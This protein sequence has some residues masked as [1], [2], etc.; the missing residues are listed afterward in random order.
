[1]NIEKIKE[2]TEK[3]LKRYDLKL[4]SIR[5]KH[6]FGMSIL[7][8][9]VDGKE[10]DAANLGK[11]NQALNE[12]IDEYLPNNYY[13]EVSTVGAIRVLHSIE[14]VKTKV[15]KYLLITKDNKSI[16]G[17]LEKVED[18]ILFIKINE[19]GR[20]KVVE[21]SFTQADEVLLTVKF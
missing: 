11:I 4:Y 13:L 8:V 15:G 5:T 20:I 19:K 7:E 3:L 6:E 9:L 16:K 14:E 17:V 10:I 2:V 21:A 1:M 12:E 18:D